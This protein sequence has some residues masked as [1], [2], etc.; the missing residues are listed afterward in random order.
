MYEDEKMKDMVPV[1]DKTSILGYD[2]KNKEQLEEFKEEL[3][4]ELEELEEEFPE[5]FNSGNNLSPPKFII[6]I[7]V[8]VIFVLR[9]FF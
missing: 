2:I 7:L 4:D 5:L 1:W 9:N 6:P 8:S 3:E